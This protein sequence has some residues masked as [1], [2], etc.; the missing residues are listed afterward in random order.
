MENNTL[1]IKAVNDKIGNTIP[2]PTYA[3]DGS[4]GFDL[5]AC[6]DESVTLNPGETKFIGTGIA[7]Q[8]PYPNLAAFLYA[9]SGLG[10]KYGIVPSNCVGVIDSDYRGEVTVALYNHSTSP[11]TVHSGDRIAQLV[12]APVHRLKIELVDNLDD[13]IR[14]TGGFGSTGK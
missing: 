5:Y 12:I 2:Y 14:G 9:R 7:V 8:I 3:T 11:F 4:A 1:K 6:I 10:R 13:T